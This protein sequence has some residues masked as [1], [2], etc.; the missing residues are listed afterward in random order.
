MK[1]WG[2]SPEASVL[3]QTPSMR[4][5]H[6][7]KPVVRVA[8]VDDPRSY[9]PRRDVEKDYDGYTFIWPFRKAPVLGARALT[10]QGKRVTVIG[11]GSRYKGELASLAKISSA[12][13]STR[14]RRGMSSGSV[15]LVVS[16]PVSG[17]RVFRRPRVWQTV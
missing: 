4:T 9:D 7:G 13:R 1:P 5:E 2:L 3:R 8:Y 14:R 6:K 12:T 11:F 15:M 17:W 10:D 16:S